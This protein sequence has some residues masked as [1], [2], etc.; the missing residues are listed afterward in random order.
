MKK[1]HFA[2][3]I[4]SYTS[5]KRVLLRHQNKSKRGAFTLIELL[6]CVSIIA[7]LASLT[8]VALSKSMHKARAISCLNNARG[9][10]LA[11]DH[12]STDHNLE[13]PPNTDGFERWF[14]YSNWVAGNMAISTEATNVS[15]LRDG[16]KTLLASYLKEVKLF[17]C[18]G[19]RSRNVRSISMNCRLNPVRREGPVRWIMD[20]G[21]QYATFRRQSDIQAPSG[22]FVT[23]D[24]RIGSINDPYFA[25]DMSNSSAL[26]RHGMVE[27]LTLVDVPANN[28]RGCTVSFADGHVEIRAWEPSGSLS[29]NDR[30]WLQTHCTYEQ[31]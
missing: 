18:P 20:T 24:E 10:V 11:W 16:N 7:L 8:Q 31:K 9:V 6:L 29:A 22:V 1:T 5:D 4:G 3:E 19:D 25:V 23:I 28:H 13:L 26:S 14:T 15:I 30:R 12:F 27:G 21:R 2:F 17:K